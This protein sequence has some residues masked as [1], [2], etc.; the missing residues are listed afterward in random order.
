MGGYMGDPDLSKSTVIGLRTATMI[1][2]EHG[3]KVE[4]TDVG[5][6]VIDSQGHSRSYG[7]NVKAGSIGRFLG[8]R[9]GGMVN[10]SYMNGGCVMSGRGVKKT[11]I[12]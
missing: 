9:N 4:P 5:I 3:L 10:K 8:Y 1:A 12:G 7:P 11:K 6:K 2:K